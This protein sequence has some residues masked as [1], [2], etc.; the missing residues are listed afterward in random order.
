MPH[1]MLDPYFQK[2][3]GR[4]LKALRNTIFWKL[5]EHKTVNGCDGLLFTCEEEKLLARQPFKPYHPKRELNVGLGT[6]A[7]PSEDPAFI[8]SFINAHP[9]LT[10]QKYW[11][12]LSRIHPK[13]GVDLLIAAY[14][15]LLAEDEN[16]PDLVVAGPGLE[17]E[18]GKDMQALASHPKIHFPGM[19]SGD[20]KWGAFY[21]CQ[22]FVLPSHQENFGIAVAEAM[23]CKIPVLISNQVNI[24]REISE[25]S[26]GL[27]D[28][29]SL[30]GTFNLLK[31]FNKLP[32]DQKQKMGAQAYEVY[33]HH[34][35]IEKAA[36]KML[37]QLNL[38][39]Q[40]NA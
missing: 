4:K 34:F 16:I 10:N 7:P 24:W 36:Q 37:N 9:K 17:T 30:E 15:K 28:I 8:T 11:L 31:T 39:L 23:A 38:V 5:F 21:G 18:Y 25:G 3:E 35:S 32:E 33:T 6:T 12:F 19:L 26:G 1:G 2:A 27:V 13:K 20:K 40:N 14:K 29:D 22:A